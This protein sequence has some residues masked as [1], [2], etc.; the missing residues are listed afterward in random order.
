MAV[1]KATVF[2]ANGFIGS[3]LVTHLSNT[4]MAC[5][6]VGRG[7]ESWRGADLGHA[8][9]CIGLTADFRAR[10]LDAIEAH[11]GYLERVLRHGRF[12]SLTYL[13]S[14]RVYLGAESTKEDAQLR[15][16]PNNPEDLYNLS[17]LMGEAACLAQKSPAVRVAR[18][19]NVYGRGMG[20]TNF[21]GS[22]VR[23]AVETRRIVLGSALS[24]EKDYVSVDAVVGALQAIAVAGRERLYNVASGKN[25]SHKDIVT[26]LENLTGCSVTTVT[27]APSIKFRPIDVTR[28]HALD[29]NKFSNLIED[30]DALVLDAR[31]AAVTSR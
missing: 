14:T 16:D 26:R 2:G 3:R 28:L 19:S 30:L 9:Y 15:V 24:S 7:D 29:L 1:V 18:L 12:K 31:S 27:D 22:I 10:P 23:D 20:A 21:L 8:F 4:G 25:I 6:G 13:S 11:I 5:T 17:K